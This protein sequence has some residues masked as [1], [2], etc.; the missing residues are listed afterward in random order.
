LLDLLFLLLLPQ[1]GD[2]LTDF[3]PSPEESRAIIRAGYA[4]PATLLVQFE[5][6]NFDET[7]EMQQLLADRQAGSS[8]SSSSSSTAVVSRP[9]SAPQS[10][11]TSAWN[12]IDEDVSMDNLLQQ[13]QELQSSL[14]YQEQQR[15][16]QQQ[17]ARGTPQ[18]Q[19]LVLQG[20]HV[21][22]CGAQFQSSLGPSPFDVVL[23]NTS[24]SGSQAELQNLANQVLVFL[25]VKRPQAVQRRASMQQQQQQ[26]PPAGPA[27]S[28]AGVAEGSS[29]DAPLAAAV[30]AAPSS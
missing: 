29:A 20:S 11:Y 13:L 3:T 17:V 21:T 9:V 2:G 7:P 10:G 4:C 26:Q 14:A 6:D 24:S 12:S 27:V 30:P 8:S 28:S 22:P 1:V 23:R 19:R 5:N 25:N 15:Q 18:L 16:Q